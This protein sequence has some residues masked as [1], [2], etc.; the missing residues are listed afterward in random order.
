M[1]AERLIS[2]ARTYRPDE[3]IHY[4]AIDMFEAGC[5]ATSVPLKVAHR[6]L[7]QSGAKA[8][9]IPGDPATALAGC[10]NSLKDVD[11]LVIDALGDPREFT[12]AWFYMPRM[13]HDGSIV[14]HYMVENAQSTPKLRFMSCS[15]VY[16]QA[17]AAGDRRRAA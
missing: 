12:N 15:D 5:T 4:A 8:R 10:A 16:L 14:A 6:R 1:R 2:L 3:V 13:L 7:S 11:L 9:L 17:Q